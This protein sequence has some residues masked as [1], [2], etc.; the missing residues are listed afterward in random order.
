[1]SFLKKLFGSWGTEGDCVP[2]AAYQAMTR[3]YQ[4]GQA[5]QFVVKNISTGVDHIQVQYLE[6]N[7]WKW[8][9]QDGKWVREGQDEFPDAPTIKILFFHQ[10]LEERLVAEKKRMKQ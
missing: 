1:M 3:R 9:T 4:L 8:S 7:E 5:V 6:N 10:F 2:R